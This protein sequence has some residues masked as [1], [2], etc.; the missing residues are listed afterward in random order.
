MKR[1]NFISTSGRIILILCYVFAAHAFAQTRPTLDDYQ[2]Q[3]RETS[4]RL[5][6][7]QNAEKNN[8]NRSQ[9]PA[10]SQKEIFEELKSKQD[11]NSG[12]MASLVI[13]LNMA[14]N[15]S[16]G[17]T[18]QR[19]A[20]RVYG[21]NRITAV[22]NI[23]TSFSENESTV[24][25]VMRSPEI[26][27]LTKSNQSK[28]K[29]YNVTPSAM[30]AAVHD[31]SCGLIIDTPQKIITFYEDLKIDRQFEIELGQVI[32]VKEAK[33]RVAK[34]SGYDS[35]EE[36]DLVNF[37]K[38][39]ATSRH[40]ISI[41]REYGVSNIESFVSATKRMNSTGYDLDVEPSANSLIAFLTDEANSKKTGKTV[42]SIVAERL[43][44]QKKQEDLHAKNFPYV[45]IFTCGN[46]R[47]VNILACLTGNK[48]TGD[49][50][51]SLNLDGQ[52]QV[53]PFHKVRS[54]GVERRDGFHVFLTKKH[55]LAMTNV[56]S[57]FVLGLVIVE[58]KSNN[59]IYRSKA[60]QFEF[61]KYSQ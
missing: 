42:K 4:S 1:E 40:E 30:W 48:H 27:A 47:H 6:Q 21:S 36:Y 13:A 45:A 57:S 49:G 39:G 10:K 59:I 52:R 55:A 3:M 19:G 61:V 58:R 53:L 11:S 41:L 5:Q 46:D 2:R 14:N 51:L 44:E 24:N 7:L 54:V 18:S 28:I 8:E 25:A 29:K 50:E 37:I 34:F 22:Q 35:V 56:N 12:Y 33:N 9:S 26:F 16:G 20:G 15:S 17:R 43:E 60:N 38:K 23:C 32:S 31:Q